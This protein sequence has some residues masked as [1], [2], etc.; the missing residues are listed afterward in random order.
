MFS[1]FAALA[2]A[3]ERLASPPAAVCVAE[4]RPSTDSDSTASGSATLRIA[5]DQN[6]AILS[7][8]HA[9]LSSA[10]TTI[11]V[12]GVRAGHGRAILFDVAAAKPQPDG[13]YIWTFAATESSS[14]EETIAAIKSGRTSLNIET[15]KYPAGEIR[16]VFR[17]SRAAQ[18]SA[19]PTPPPSLPGGTPTTQDGA[20]LLSQSTFGATEVL[21]AHVQKVG[22]DAFLREQM[23]IPASSHLKFVDE[24]NEPRKNMDTTM[25]AWWTHAIAGPDQLRQRVAFALSEIFVVSVRTDALNTRLFAIANY[26]DVLVNDAFSNYRQLLEDV[27]LNPAMGAYLNMLHNGKADPAKGTHPN[28]N[29][30]REILQLFSI[31]LYRL[32]LD[33]SLKL[34]AKGAPIPAYDQRAVMG[35]AAAFTGWHYAQPKPTRWKGVRPDYRRP[36]V[37]V[38]K[39]H[40]RSAKTILDGVVLSAN[41]TPEQDLKQALDTI[42]KHPNVAPFI[43]RQLIQRLVTSNP[44]PGYIYRVAS[45]FKNNGRGVRGDLA[46]VVRAI[47]TDY[48]ARAAGANTET[49][50]KMREPVLRLTNLL[51]AFRASTPSGRF[52]INQPGPL[53]QVP[54]H[55]PT[56]FNFFSPDYQAPGAIAE[57]GLTSPEF[58]ITTETTAVTAANYLYRAIFEHI[59]APGHFISLGLTKE[60]TLADDPEKLV[61]RLD[62]LLTSGSMS[63]EMRKILVRAIEKIPAS[64][65]IARAK[66]AI[67]LVITSPEFVVEK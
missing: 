21:I 5:P 57:S 6:S 19:A 58:Q 10:P 7:F 63:A 33:G 1:Y 46:A 11:H 16:G 40:D 13:T 38:P 45:V 43:S 61:E 66:T 56:V 3:E 12:D 28:E 26:M 41:Q 8:Q 54:M 35:L 48:E 49:T 18:T 37:A 42:F 59:G 53:G 14:V 4:L 39:Q 64:Q 27:T 36:M 31:G 22:V 17:L 52:A 15:E 55:S 60:E 51:R 34:D 67:Y 20:R 62:L 29:Y 50:G 25:S 65:R 2:S 47:L 24:V 32:N 9:N 44:S 30:A 23:Q